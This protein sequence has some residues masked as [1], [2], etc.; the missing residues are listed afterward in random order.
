[1]PGLLERPSLLSRRP[2]SRGS[3]ARQFVALSKVELREIVATDKIQAHKAPLFLEPIFCEGAEGLSQVLD[4][5]MPYRRRV[6][7]VVELTMMAQAVKE[8]LPKAPSIR[9]GRPKV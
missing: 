8:F 5:V 7:T 2:I 9:R 4:D 3:D 6:V 1:M